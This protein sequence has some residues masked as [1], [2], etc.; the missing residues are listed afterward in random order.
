MSFIEK[1]EQEL[2]QTTT[3]N[4]DIAYNSTGN[5]CLDYFTLVGGYRGDN[6]MVN[7][8]F[9]K[10]YQENRIDA[11]KL[12]L[13]TR[14]IRGGIGERDLFRGLLALI[15][16]DEVEFLDK[17]IPIIKDY[18]R[19]DDL[20]SLIGTKL[21]DNVIK[22]IG[23]TLNQDVSLKKEGKEYS[24]LAKWMPSV[25]TSNEYQ[26]KLARLIAR[27]LGLSLKDYRKTLSYLREGMIIENNLR[28]KSY[29]FEYEGVPSK[30]LN[31]Y[32]NAFNR[33]DF[34]RWNDFL[35]ASIKDPSVMH[36]EVLDVVNFIRQIKYSYNKD[37]SKYYKATWD[38]LVNEGE[39][40][41]KCLVVRDGSGS[42]TWGRSKIAPLDIAD[43]MSLLHSARL[44]G[45][46]KDKFVTFS[47]NPELIDLSSIEKIEDK[48]KMLGR[49]DECS[50]TNIERVFNLVY[51]VYNSKD[52]KEEDALDQIV[53]ISDMQFDSAIEYV[54]GGYMSCYEIFKK[55][56]D[57]KGYKT[58]E[59]VFWN[60]NSYGTVPVGKNEA[61]V[62][63][64]SGSSKA[65]IN[66]V[67]NIK[68]IDPMD[69]M[70]KTLLKYKFV[71]ELA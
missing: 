26:R 38:T 71:E 52:F 12:M 4:G 67:S 44:T 1:A 55:K 66:L 2:N 60:V 3:L 63:L 21:E 39:V 22:Y 10:A 37:E 30:A 35:E 31:K 15:S 29:N 49:Y 62:K 23:E 13:Y 32:R 40:K 46:F 20:L 16:E 64:I 7:Y 36:T 51:D 24:L 41:G 5:K 57:D 28:E 33:N 17:L 53:I 34:D 45:P 18:G 56:M 47:S 27:K 58:P 43:A 8:L 54:S 25:N 6:L 48:V 14:D 61:G 65:I 9:S 69:M 42:M 70:N 11:L 68:S 50:N 59:I 19:F